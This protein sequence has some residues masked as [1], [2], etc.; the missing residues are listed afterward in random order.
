MKAKNTKHNPIRSQ[1]FTQPNITFSTP[2][3][4]KKFSNK[5]TKLKFLIIMLAVIV[6]FVAAHSLGISNDQA[7][8]NWA[9]QRIAYVQNHLYQSLGVQVNSTVTKDCEFQNA[10][11]GNN[12]PLF[13]NQE[14]SWSIPA[15]IKGINFTQKLGSLLASSNVFGNVAI[16]PINDYPFPDKNTWC[17]LNITEPNNSTPTAVMASDQNSSISFNLT[18]RTLVNHQFY[19]LK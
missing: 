10:E 8:L 1:R 2:G 5:P 13:C 9:Y 6:G 17:S 19:P 4:Y 3:W 15:R 18:C 7:H 16:D 14:L 11:F 12:G